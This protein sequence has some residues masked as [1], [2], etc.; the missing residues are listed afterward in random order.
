[1]ITFVLSDLAGLCESAAATSVYTVSLWCNELLRAHS[2]RTARDCESVKTIELKQVGSWIIAAVAAIKTMYASNTSFS[3][4]YAAFPFSCHGLHLVPGFI[5]FLNIALKAC[6]YRACMA[7]SIRMEASIQ[8]L[9]SAEE[10]KYIG[11]R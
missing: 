10:V 3:Q 2:D 9:C 1:M 7:C 6:G 5:T 8:N 4:R 11:T